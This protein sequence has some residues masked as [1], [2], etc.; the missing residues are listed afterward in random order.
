MFY[1]CS[2][3]FILISFSL[4][5]LF[6]LSPCFTLFSPNPFKVISEFFYYESAFL[7]L[8]NNNAQIYLNEPKEK[9]LLYT[10]GL[11]NS[12]RLMASKRYAQYRQGLSTEKRKVIYTPEREIISGVRH[13]VFH[14]HSIAGL[15]LGV[16]QQHKTDSIFL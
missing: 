7:H 1:L 9:H 3:A 5:L 8:E 14:P 11:V 16:L 12:Q 10:S 4:L 2:S 15:M 13:W 6:F